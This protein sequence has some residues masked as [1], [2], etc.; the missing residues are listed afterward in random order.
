M[1]LASATNGSTAYVGAST[2]LGSRMTGLEA[3]TA[4]G[5]S[6][7]QA[8]E[9]V[10]PKPG[11]PENL[12]KRYNFTR[13]RSRAGRP[14]ARE[15]LPVMAM[16][17][18]IVDAIN[19]NEVVVISGHTGSPPRD[20]HPN[21]NPIPLPSHNNTHARHTIVHPRTPCGGIKP[22]RTFEKQA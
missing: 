17:Q 13:P 9:V 3:D 15:R 1:A 2:V 7:G 6:L 10:P 20:R 11:K 14:D 8:A 5:T 12:E 18:E 19:L 16:R 4:P 22:H 21:P